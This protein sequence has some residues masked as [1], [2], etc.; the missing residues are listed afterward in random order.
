MPLRLRR[1]VQISRRGASDSPRLHLLQ[2]VV[3]P[4]LVGVGDGHVGR[5]RGLVVDLAREAAE[6]VGAGERGLQVEQRV[7]VVGRER[8]A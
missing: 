3:D 1:D 5:G 4:T 2:Q 6:V 7:A 8:A